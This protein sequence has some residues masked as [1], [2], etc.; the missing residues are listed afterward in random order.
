MNLVPT[1]SDTNSIREYKLWNVAFIF[2]ALYHNICLKYVRLLYFL[3]RVCA[4]PKDTY[5][6]IDRSVN[7]GGSRISKR[8]VVVHFRSHAHFGGKTTPVFDC[9]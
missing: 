3:V 2:M 1:F 4:L 5:P 6:F 9:F 8:G 7:S